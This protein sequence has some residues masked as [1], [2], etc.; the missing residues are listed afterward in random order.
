MSDKFIV[1]SPSTVN[2]TVTTNMAGYVIDMVWRFNSRRGR[3]F[4]DL[5]RSSTGDTARG[6][7]LKGNDAV[8]M[9]NATWFQKDIGSLF[10]ERVNERVDIEIGKDSIFNGDF[11]MSLT[12]G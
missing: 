7:M 2:Q 1:T 12:T 10:V 6:L 9:Q 4:V 8:N 11:I 3:W 5:I